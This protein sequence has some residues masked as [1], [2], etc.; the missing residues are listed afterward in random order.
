MNLVAFDKPFQFYT[1]I[2]VR[3]SAGG[4]AA[5]MADNHIALLAASNESSQKSTNKSS[6]RNQCGRRFSPRHRAGCA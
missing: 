1:S 4:D 2:N 3:I 6:R 5:L